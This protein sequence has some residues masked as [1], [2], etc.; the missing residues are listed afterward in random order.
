MAGF[1]LKEQKE[2]LA[3]QDNG[4][5]VHLRGLDGELLY[6]GQ[7]K[8]VTIT[9][10]G[11]HSSRWRRAEEA[12]RKRRIAGETIEDGLTVAETMAACTDG[13][14]GITN[15]AKPHPFTPENAARL[16]ADFP[17]VQSQVMA[18]M[19]TPGNFT[20]RP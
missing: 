15:G 14:D 11:R 17:F 18:A 9:V 13:W 2:V 6:H 4:F 16:Y 19:I 10:V 1:D 5:P 8:P 7:E 12:L 20:K 3:A